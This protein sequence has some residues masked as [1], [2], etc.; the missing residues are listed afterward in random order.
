MLAVVTINYNSEYLIKNLIQ[1]LLDIYLGNDVIFLISNNSENDDLLKVVLSDY[2]VNLNNKIFLINNKKNIGYAKANNK[3]FLFLYNNNYINDDDIIL[4]T[5]P[6]IKINDCYLFEKINDSFK[7]FNADFLGPKIV[8]MDFTQMLPHLK[9]GN[10]FTTLLHLGNNG[11]VDKIIKYNY[12]IKN[13]KDPIEVF[14]LNG[15]FLFCKVKSFK[16]AGMFDENTFL[17]LEE[18]IFFRKV[19]KLGMKVIYDPQIS[20]FHEHSGIVKKE[21]GSLVKKE[22]LFESEKYLLYNILK[23]GKAK[24]LFFIIERKIEFFLFKLAILIRQILIRQ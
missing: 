4:F 23:C 7:K 6:D 14:L 22:V 1:N 13:V 8:N 19:K 21:I 16:K 17:Y 10:Y 11:I 9:E 12:H 5:N 3:A 18:E 24:F 2:I 20:V 15:S